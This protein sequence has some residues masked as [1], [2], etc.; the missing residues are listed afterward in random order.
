[1]SIAPDS[2]R[3]EELFS[4]L[5]GLAAPRRAAALAAACGDDRQLRED[6]ERLLEA[7]DAA[8]AEHFLEWDRVRSAAEAQPDALLG[9]RLGPYQIVERIAAGAMGV[10]YRA[11]RSQ[12]FKQKVAVKVL[13]P[14][15]CDQESIARFRAEQ[16]A[17]ADLPHPHIARMLDAGITSDG[18]HYLIL[19]Y[20]DGHRLDEAIAAWQPSLQVKLQWFLQICRAVAFAHSRGI[21]HRDLKPANILLATSSPTSG[22]IA[23][24]NAGGEPDGPSSLVPTIT[25]FGLAKITNDRGT[26][27]TATGD[28]LGTPGYM[29]PE[30]VQG[31]QSGNG[32]HS[33]VYGLG[34]VLYFLLTGKPPFRG[35]S[36]SELIRD[37]EQRDPD[38][39]AKLVSRIPLDINTICLKCLEKQQSDRYASVDELADD[40]QRYLAGFPVRARPIGVLGRIVRWS[41]RNR[42]IAALA[43]LLLA[44][45]VLGLLVTT[46]LFLTAAHEKR[47]A[48]RE[49]KSAIDIIDRMLTEVSKSL[50][51][52]PG[53]SELRQ[54]LL[55]AAREAYDARLSQGQKDD[56]RL[57]IETA[58]AT[59]RLAQIQYQALQKEEAYRTA[60]DA[61]AQFSELVRLYPDEHAFHF[62]VFHCLLL[63]DQTQEALEHILRLSREH[64]LAIYRQ[65]AANTA[66]RVAGQMSAAQPPR[67][68]EL[69]MIALAIA[70]DLD[71]E[72][73]GDPFY[74]RTR[75][76]VF[77]GLATLKRCTGEFDKSMQYVQQAIPI[78]EEL[79][80]KNPRETGFRGDLVSDLNVAGWMALWQRKGR[81]ADGYF[82]RAT[83][84]ALQGT[85]LTPHQLSAW[86]IYTSALRSSMENFQGELDPV[87]PKFVELV[88]EYEFALQAAARCWKTVDNQFDLFYAEFL[89]DAPLLQFRDLRKAQ[90]ITSDLPVAEEYQGILGIIQ[91]RSGHPQQALESFREL[92]PGHR[93]ANR[94]RAMHAA[95]AWAQLGN[96]AE[97]ERVFEQLDPLHHTQL[98]RRILAEVDEI[99]RTRQSRAGE[100]AEGQ[101]AAEIH[102]ISKSRNSGD[103]LSTS[104]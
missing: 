72:F 19:E 45:L 4:E 97:A 90:Q 38:P 103:G 1:M 3:V 48:E 28:L 2:Q 92:S 87:D 67:A 31:T 94:E 47:I 68:E 30:Q 40:V 59:Y 13:R 104:I 16:Q 26:A 99:K 80:Q 5:A 17:L 15:L 18:S 50:V 98:Y 73:P 46:S 85:Q 10:V 8:S 37:L 9:R 79:V 71:K 62:D 57:Q 53:S 44:T 63:L 51:N 69:L 27:L 12:G 43:G 84:H 42:N 24:E 7:D 23:S 39:P 64:P 91:L 54:S 56:K 21:A 29:A 33:D 95:L 81:E 36:I 83:A 6:V 74:R 70:R 65:A 100:A 76:H 96:L 41:K 89:A 35:G 22:P 58:T 20:I 102:A 88:S 101:N 34:A 60:H 49:R 14:W 52:L 55:A 93:A 11:E 78:R 66:C 82:S 86:S 61:M 32:F 77:T 25:D 75:A